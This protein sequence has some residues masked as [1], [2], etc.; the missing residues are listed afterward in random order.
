[1]QMPFISIC[2]PAYKRTEFLKR[3][4][5]SI[6]VQT[7]KDFEVIVTD[8]SAGNEVEDLTRL[9]SGRFVIKYFKNITALGTPEN[10]NEGIRHAS[11]DWIKLMHDDDWFASEDSLAQF[12]GC[13][14]QNPGVDF[15]FS[16]YTNQFLER[17]TAKNVFINSYRYKKL[18]RDSVTLFSQNVI[19][20]PSVILHKS[21]ANVFYDKN[22]KW[23][24]DIDFYIQY[25]K[26][27]R[28]AYINSPLINVGIGPEQV[29]RDCFRQRAI[30]IPEAFHLFNKL[31]FGRMKNVLV[32]DAW[33]RLV[34][35]LEIK[36]ARDIAASG[37]RG[38]LPIAIQS[39]IR[40]Q[41]KM[42][43]FV[44]KT[45]IFS[46]VLMFLNYLFNYNRIAD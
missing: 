15:V 22:L 13:I 5:D 38:E 30:E 32:Y 33:W 9:Y 19:G 21:N 1:M 45:G 16:A 2:I 4:L 6:T 43:A 27:G 14:K 25:L 20:P 28:I 12:A 44:L 34:R 17:N 31:G 18:K 36:S 42:P 7:F 3:L 41:S 8:D 24:V 40:W 35:N 39:I 37:Y 11:G 46:K 23:L 26:A 10:W 29:T